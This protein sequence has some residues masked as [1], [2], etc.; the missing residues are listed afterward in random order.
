[1]GFHQGCHKRCWD[2]STTRSVD[3]QMEKS[4]FFFWIELGLKILNYHGRQPFTLNASYV[5]LSMWWWPKNCQ[6]NTRNICTEECFDLFWS[7][8]EKKLPALSMF[9][10]VN[11][12]K[13]G[14]LPEL[15]LGR[16]SVAPQEV[17]KLAFFPPLSKNQNCFWLVNLFTW[18]HSRSPS[19][20]YFTSKQK[21]SKTKWG[22]EKLSR[23]ST[24]ITWPLPKNL[25]EANETIKDRFERKGYKILSK[26]YAI[27]TTEKT[28]ELDLQKVNEIYSPDI[29]EDLLKSQLEDL[30]SGNERP[31]KYLIASRHTPCQSKEDDGC[32]YTEIREYALH[33]QVTIQVMKNSI[34]FTVQISAW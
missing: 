27:L 16:R 31:E 6:V 21:S 20:L 34:S 33:A 26:L 28:K 11:G 32:P 5:N 1:M 14:S 13:A 29:K 30:H 23:T 25:F 4:D 7:Y 12:N 17:R 19:H 15:H 8:L 9:S 24:H 18:L 2:E 3:G 10:Q 22:W